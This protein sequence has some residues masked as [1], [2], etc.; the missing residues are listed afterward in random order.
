MVY[1]EDCAKGIMAQTPPWIRER[2]GM[3]PEGDHKFRPWI[4]HKQRKWE[5]K[6]K[7][8]EEGGSAEKAR[9]SPASRENARDKA[10]AKAMVDAKADSKAK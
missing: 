1:T 4:K 9:L 7:R 5:R 3:E 10:K 6:R 8:A 2:H